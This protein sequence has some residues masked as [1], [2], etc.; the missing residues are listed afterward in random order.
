MSWLSSCAESSSLSASRVLA[1]FASSGMVVKSS[2]D[3]WL[4][5]LAVD[6][7]DCGIL[8]GAD[9]NA[10]SDPAFV[11]IRFSVAACDGAGVGWYCATSS[12]S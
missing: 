1:E 5:C 4:R 2:A 3:C 11:A 6:A 12:F 9:A 8:E 7:L 10:V